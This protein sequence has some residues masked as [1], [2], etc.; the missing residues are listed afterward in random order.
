MTRP[1]FH[2]SSWVFSPLTLSAMLGRF[3][4]TSFLSP[5][6]SVL[7]LAVGAIPLV[8]LELVKVV[9]QAS[10]LRKAEP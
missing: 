8:M 10:R 2:I 6:D 3:L 5:V 1:P 4:G 9:R 7:L